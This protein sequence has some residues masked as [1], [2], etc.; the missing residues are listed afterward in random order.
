M[1]FKINQS[2]LIYSVFI[3]IKALIMLSVLVLS[4]FINGDLISNCAENVHPITISAII[5]A[6]SAFN[7]YAIGINSGKRLKKQ[8]KSFDEAYAI[9]SSLLK[10]GHN[11]DL[12][13]GQ[14]NSNNLDWLNLDLNSV[15][16]PCKNIKA[17][18]YVLSYNFDLVYDESL[19]YQY[20]LKKALSM[21]NTGNTSKGF[22]NGYVA[23]V[24][25][26]AKKQLLK[27]PLESSN[28]VEIEIQRN[29]SKPLFSDEVQS[30]K[31]YDNMSVYYENETETNTRE[32]IKHI[33]DPQ[34]NKKD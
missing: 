2:M 32:G 11:I 17:I 24:S 28:E 10:E 33:Y 29:E 13:L 21:Y 18:D 15:F 4:G 27:I 1:G 20:N 16:D 31:R 14:I 8:P 6:E 30:F 7:P 5:E 22:N 25:E 23:K 19:D 3:Q 34:G 9:A 26:K 12:G